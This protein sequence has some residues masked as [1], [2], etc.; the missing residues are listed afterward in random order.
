MVFE[1]LNKDNAEDYIAYLKVAMSEE[2]DN[3]TAEKL[4]ENGIRHKGVAQMLFKEN[5]TCP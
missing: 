2:P 4:D 3:M 5:E 1:K